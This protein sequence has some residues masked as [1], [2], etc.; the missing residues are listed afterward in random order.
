MEG[1][2]GG[3]WSGVGRG[4]HLVALFF[5]FVF[6]L[7]IGSVCAKEPAIFTIDMVIILA[8]WYWYE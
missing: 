3:L 5:V 2:G 8:T 4:I 6:F 1:G 7:I